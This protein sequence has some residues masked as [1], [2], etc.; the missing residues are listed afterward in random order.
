MRVVPLDGEIRV[1]GLSV[2]SDRLT[3]TRSLT[4]ASASAPGQVGQMG[5]DSD[6]VYVCVAPD[7]WR[8]AALADW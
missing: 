1:E 4:P 8:R 3:L 2:R 6:H 7:Q 5:W